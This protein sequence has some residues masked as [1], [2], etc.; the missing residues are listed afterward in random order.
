M[1]AQQGINN[2]ECKSLTYQKKKLINRY[3]M[4]PKW[5]LLNF[6]KTTLFVYFL[7]QMT[8]W[9][10][11]SL[12][13]KIILSKNLY[14]SFFGYSNIKFISIFKTILFYFKRRKFTYIIN[15]NENKF[16]QKKLEEFLVFFTKISHQILINIS[17]NE[18]KNSEIKNI[19][20]QICCNY[21][22]VKIHQRYFSNKTAEFQ[23]PLDY[24][25]RNFKETTHI[26]IMNDD[27]LF[28]RKKLERINELLKSIKYFNRTLINND[29][30]ILAYPNRD[31]VHFSTTGKISCGIL[32]INI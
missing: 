27:K 19:I 3:N 22:N 12:I 15:V 30:E 18:I 28:S 20:E 21:K 1:Q 26:V 2:L 31:F 9:K 32:K 5:F 13:E 17:L 25:K 6:E 8:K 10:N 24:I 23:Y 29:S 7:I 14:H 4:K 16:E 11:I